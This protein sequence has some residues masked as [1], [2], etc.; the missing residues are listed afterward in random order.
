MWPPY[1][2]VPAF[3]ERAVLALGAVHHPDLSLR[4]EVARA[5]N[6]SVPPGDDNPFG[7]RVSDHPDEWGATPADAKTA[8]AGVQGILGATRELTLTLTRLDEIPFQMYEEVILDHAS[9]DAVIGL[10]FDFREIAKPAEDHTDGACP[11]LVR[12]TPLG[13]EA[14]AVPNVRSATFRPDYQGEV[15][16]FDDS[17]EIPA[18]MAF[19]WLSLLRASRMGGGAFWIV[20]RV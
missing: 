2:C 11:H 5:C 6:V 9:D 7:L 19:S 18:F 8:F 13:N 15:H 14:S 12:M 1:C 16:V 4:A 3:F 17:G 20:E 10:G